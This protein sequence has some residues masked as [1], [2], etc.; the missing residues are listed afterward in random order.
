MGTEFGIAIIGLVGALIGAAASVAGTIWTERLRHR[1]EASERLL[2]G[3]ASAIIPGDSVRAAAVSSKLRL[4]GAA[5]DKAIQ[6]WVGQ[7]DAEASFD[8]MVTVLTG[9]LNN[10]RKTQGLNA[11]SEPTVRALIS[12]QPS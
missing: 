11:L 5:D 6:N 2:G 1:Q 4:A 3:F 7:A 9:V 10:V 12:G 8:A